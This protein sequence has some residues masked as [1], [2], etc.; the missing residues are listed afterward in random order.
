MMIG[1]ED[2]IDQTKA[3]VITW[4][5]QLHKYP[6]LSFQEEKTAQFVYDKLCTLK[7]L[8]VSRPTKTSVMARLIGSLPGNVLAIRADMD[9]LPMQEE[10]SFEFTSQNPGVMHACGHDAHTAMLLGTATILS[11]LQDQI[12]G[13]VRFIFQHAE[14]LFPG[15]SREMIQAGAMADVDK[16]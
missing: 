16:I 13:E 3:D 5:R 11:Q 12:Q 9:A 8:E 1:I 14:E 10:N 15:G 7:K 2:L 6:E 4:R